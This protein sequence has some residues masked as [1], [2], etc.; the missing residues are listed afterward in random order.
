MV[1]ID[2]MVP[3]SD[4]SVEARSLE[5]ISEIVDDGWSTEREY[6]IERIVIAA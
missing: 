5:P 3:E 6:P 4:E 2:C 1:S